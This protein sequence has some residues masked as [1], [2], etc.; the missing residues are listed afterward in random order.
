MT[1]NTL[2]Q[3]K[4]QLLRASGAGISLPVAGILF[5]LSLG[6]AGYFLNPKMWGLVACFSSGLIFPLGLLLSKSFGSN[7]LVKD[8]PLSSLALRA[9]VSINLLWPLHFA[10]YFTNPELLPLSLAIGMGIH[11]PIIGWMYGSSACFQHAIIRVAAVSAVWFLYPAG[12]FTVL[13]FVVA[14]TYLITIFQLRREL[15]AANNSVQS[16]ALKTTRASS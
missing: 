8:Q 2:D 5:W 6:V 9:V 16:D 4:S 3:A 13:P 1:I 15:E 12:R 10:V 14:V 11:W 7:L